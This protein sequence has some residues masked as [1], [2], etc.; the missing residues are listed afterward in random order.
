[1]FQRFSPCMR[2]VSILAVTFII[3]SIIL[4]CGG[5]KEKLIL[6]AT[7][8]VQDAGLLDEIVR[9][10]EM[11]SDYDLI[12]VVGGSGQILEMAR[13]GEFDV[14]M[15]HSPAD[16]EQFIVDGEGLDPRQV[17]ENYFVLVGPKDDPAGV[18]GVVSL[19]EALKRI[20]SAEQT[21]ISRGDN[22]GTHERELSIWQSLLIDPKGQNWYRESATGQ[23][24]N[25]LI[26]NDDA[27]YT[28]VD[29]STFVTFGSRVQL[30]PLVTDR[31]K[32]NA[33]TV[34]RINREK[35]QHVN[36]VGAI[37][38]VEFITSAAGQCLIAEFGRSEYGKSLFVPV[39]GCPQAVGH[40]GLT[41]RR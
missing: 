17:M 27:A 22:S 33:Y 39:L 14:I 38:F 8:S 13:R 29:T 16:E 15:T 28:L 32:P 12:P 34:I 6:G 30:M 36:V 24:Q 10:F 23:G 41:S 35:H 31:V 1:M 18:V 7:T 21:F 4:G 26:A 2:L 19:A 5:G 25:L 3:S 37:A 11:H 20:A 9:A 40:L